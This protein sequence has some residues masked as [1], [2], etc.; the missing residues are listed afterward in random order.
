MCRRSSSAIAVRRSVAATCS[1]SSGLRTEWSREVPESQIGYHSAPASAAACSEPTRAGS[2]SSTRSRSLAGP[3]ERRPREPIAASAAPPSPGTASPARS[4]RVRS[5]SSTRSDWASL[6]EGPAEGSAK[7]SWSTWV[8]RREESSSE[9]IRPPFPGAHAHRGA[10]VGGPDL[11]VADP[12]GAG[13]GE[14]QFDDRGLVA[15]QREHLDLDL[16]DRVD[17][18]L[19]AAVDLGV[20]ALAAVAG[21]LGEGQARHPVLAQGVGDVLQDVRLDDDGD[22]L[23]RGAPATAGRV[24][25]SA[26]SAPGPAASR[27]GPGPSTGPSV[28]ARP[29][30][31]GLRGSGPGSRVG[32]AGAEERS[33]REARAPTRSYPASA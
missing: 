29:T 30:G 7:P 6:R 26:A 33:R 12:P 1:H 17:G 31:A 3:R 32:K 11:P 22:Q 24:V 10:N 23:H 13:G 16:G 25:S 2:T 21:D 8:I 18:V 4:H 27:T 20:A 19:G 15:L 28:A 9:G 14:D 5:Q